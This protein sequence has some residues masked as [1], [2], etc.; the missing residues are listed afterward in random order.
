MPVNGSASIRISKRMNRWPIA[1]LT[2]GE[3]PVAVFGSGIPIAV[4]SAPS[5][6]I[7]KQPDFWPRRHGRPRAS[8]KT[9][10]GAANSIA[11]APRS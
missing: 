3:N 4:A 11:S 10:S 7:A 9:T 1:M 8:S 2:S 6:V 5:H